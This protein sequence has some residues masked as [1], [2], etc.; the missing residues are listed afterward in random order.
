ML[1]IPGGLR[2]KAGGAAAAELDGEPAEEP[3][4]ALRIARVRRVRDF[5]GVL[6]FVS[7]QR[8]KAAF[9]TTDL[10]GDAEIAVVPLGDDVVRQVAAQG[11]ACELRLNVD[12]DIGFIQRRDQ[13]AERRGT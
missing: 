4:E 10:N 5:D 11:L 13:T 3:L 6:E 1:D 8:D 7:E 12:D 2:F 9:C